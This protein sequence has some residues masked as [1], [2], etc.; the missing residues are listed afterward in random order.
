MS[1]VII[2]NEEVNRNATL[3]AAPSPTT[4]GVGTVPERSPLSCPPPFCSGSKRTRGRRRTAVQLV[5][6]DGHQVDLPVGDVDGNLTDGLSGVGVEEDSFRATDLTCG[7]TED[8]SIALIGYISVVS[9]SPEHDA[10]GPAAP[11]E[12]TTS[13]RL[14]LPVCFELAALPSEPSRVQSLEIGLSSREETV[15]PGESI[16]TSDLQ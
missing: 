10:N 3:Q 12:P 11:N 15:L 14:P 5:A 16:W 13:L 8:Q 2:G 7:R 1:L 4:S 9:P 6:A